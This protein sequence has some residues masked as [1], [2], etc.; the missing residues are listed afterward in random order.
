M[1]AAKEI[2]PYLKDL[3]LLCGYLTVGGK[4]VA[5]SHRRALRRHAHHPYRKGAARLS[6]GVPDVAQLFAQTFADENV[7]Y[8]N[9]ED[10][11]GDL[12]LQE[13]QTQLSARGDR[14]QI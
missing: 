3:G 11:S 13:I 6:R 9:R 8:I 12:G 2:L 14:G 10:D 5:A 7:H 1:K 4:I